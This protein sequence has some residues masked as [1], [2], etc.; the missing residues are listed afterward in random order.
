MPIP[1]SL[2]II[3]KDYSVETSKKI[4]Y[5]DDILHGMCIDTKCKIQISTED[6][7]QQQKDT[8]IHEAI[9]AIDYAM[10][11]GLKEKQV[12]L[13]GTAIY[14]LLNENPELIEWIL[15]D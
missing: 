15:E 4:D 11:I 5:G 10:D 7:K 9:H 6:D 1:K 2:R 12:R 8:L 14:S 3:G 13:L